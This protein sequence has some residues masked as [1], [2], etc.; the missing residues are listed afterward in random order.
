MEFKKL[1]HQLERQNFFKNIALKATEHCLKTFD[2]NEISE[3]EEKCL[4]KASLNL[5]SIVER[6][7]FEQYA[8]YGNPSQSW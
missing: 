2:S 6:N 4:K 5:Y 3:D 8:I 1:T 7:R